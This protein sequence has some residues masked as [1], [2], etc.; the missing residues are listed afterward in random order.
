V[1]SFNISII[2]YKKRK[3][4]NVKI[5]R[6][7]KIMENSYLNTVNLIKIKWKM[8]FIKNK[9]ISVLTISIS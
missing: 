9:N 4:I 5:F 6:M 8:T 7:V 3:K 2:K 1:G